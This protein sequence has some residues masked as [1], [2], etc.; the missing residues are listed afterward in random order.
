MVIDMAITLT[1]AKFENCPELYRLQIKSFRALLEKYQDYDFSPGAERIERT[2]ERFHQSIT[3]FW[4]ISLDEK[5][6]GAIRVCDFGTLCKLKQIFIVPEY[7][8]CGYAQEAIKAVEAIYP[9][10]LRWE[11]E[12]IL[13]EEKLCYLYDKM[14]YTKTSRVETIKEGMDLVYY[15][16][17]RH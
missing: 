1:K 3:D 15:A 14:G 5:N 10:A 11:L 17:E 6:I 8:N 13:Q 12:T 9:H 4:M 16:K 2:Y 7:Q